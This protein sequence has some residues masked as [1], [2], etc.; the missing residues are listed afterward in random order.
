MTKLA[1]CGLK[2]FFSFDNTYH[3]CNLLLKFPNG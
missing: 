2:T 1:I 3:V